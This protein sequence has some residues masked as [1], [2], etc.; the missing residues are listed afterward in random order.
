MSRLSAAFLICISI[1][2]AADT[3]SITQAELV[4]RTQE[5]YDAVASGSRTPWKQYVAEDA[6]FFDEKGRSMDKRALL[7]DLK[8]LPVG[9]S[10]TIRVDRAASRF[11]TNVAI[12][13][14]DLEETETV[15]G[16]E[17]H[18][19]YHAT[20]TWLRRNQLWQIVAS[21]TLRYYEDPAAGTVSES[22][23]NDYVGRYQLAPKNVVTIT[24]RGNDL[25][26]QRGTGEPYKLLPESPDLYFRPG[27]EGRRLFHRDASGHVDMLID[28][29]NNE[30]LLWKKLP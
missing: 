1:C 25:Y 18:A 15:F 10:G 21:Q 20:D 22:M 14:Y 26:A 13:S 7:D 23:L 2:R 3:P 8:P 12:V 17:L 27:V 28:R 4:R 9:Y 30:D 11:A 16:R 6:M 5:L 19:R 24:R 29:R